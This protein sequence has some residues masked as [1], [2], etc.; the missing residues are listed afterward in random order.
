MLKHL[1]GILGTYMFLVGSVYL[2]LHYCIFKRFWVD[3]IIFNKFYV[4]EI[5]CLFVSFFIVIMFF[6]ISLT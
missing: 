6:S 5:V 2:A 4:N 3:K 1:I